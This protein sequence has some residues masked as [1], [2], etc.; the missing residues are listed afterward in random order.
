MKEEKKVNQEEQENT[1]PEKEP[2]TK[3]SK[4]G[5]IKKVCTIGERIVTGGL[6]AV[7]CYALYKAVKPEPKGPV[8][9]KSNE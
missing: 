5:L 3:K 9:N 1:T 2:E 4:L 7:G 8:N 6:A